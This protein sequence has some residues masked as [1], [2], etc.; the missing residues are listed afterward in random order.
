MGKEQTKTTEDTKISGVCRT[1]NK[2]LY[3]T[4]LLELQIP[5]QVAFFCLQTIQTVYNIVLHR[6]L[7]LASQIAIALQKMAYSPKKM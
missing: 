3:F 2:N 1:N 4:L 7:C 6:L 5:V